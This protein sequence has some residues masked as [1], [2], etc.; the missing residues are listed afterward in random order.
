[1]G[2]IGPCEFH[3]FGLLQK[4]LAIKQFATDV[5]EKQVVNFGLQTLDT[6]VFYAAAQARVLRWEK[7][8]NV[9]SE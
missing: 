9:N 5:D 7:Y 6:D 2:T 3:L 4:H 8:L 1:L